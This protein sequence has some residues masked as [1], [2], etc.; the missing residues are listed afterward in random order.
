[1]LAM[2]RHAYCIMA[3][4]NWRQLQLLIGTLDDARNDIFLHIDKKVKADFDVWG[5]NIEVR[6]SKLYYVENIDVRWGDIS[7][8]DCEMLLFR[9]VVDMGECYSRVHLISGGDL[10]LKS[11][12]EIHNFF[13]NKKEEFLVVKHDLKFVRRL[14]FYHFFV[15]DIR[16]SL[17]ANIFRRVLLVPQVFLINRLK[18]CPL[19]FA[20]GSEWCSLTFDAVKYLCD[21]APKYRRIFRF[22]TCCDELYKQMI[23]SSNPRF[24]Y[25]DEKEGNLRYVDFSA[26]LPSP[27]TLTMADYDKIIN[28]GCLFARKFDINKDRTIVDKILTRLH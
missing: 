10:P 24:I 16:T 8:L 7:L 3:H 27:K 4:C 2:D 22:S 25:S 17:I 6:Y 21:S 1:M 12:D 15:R 11:Q 19:R 18:T 5:G 28:S 14:K 20:Y 26:R 23:L 9:K 13:L